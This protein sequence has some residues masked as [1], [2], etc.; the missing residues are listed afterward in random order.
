[1][2]TPEK[3]DYKE[4]IINLQE[5]SNAK[6]YGKENLIHQR[7]FDRA[8]KLI[9]ARLVRPEAIDKIRYNDTISILGS[10][11]SGKTSFLLSLLANYKDSK[12]VEVLNII[13]PTLIEEK[14]HVFLT[15]ISLI[16]ESVSKRLNLSDCSPDDSSYL[17]KKEW[18]DKLRKLAD[19]LPSMDGVGSS[20]EHSDWQDTEFIM[21][22][23]LKSVKAA[24]NLEANFN[25]LVCCALRALEK[26]VFI[27][28]LDDIDVDFRKGW[29]VLE[30]I[31]KY[32]TSP[33]IIVLLSGDLKLYAKAIRKQQWKNFGKALLKNEAEALNKMNEY[34][35]LVTEMEGQ[36]MQKVIKPENRIRLTTLFEKIE[37]YN[38]KIFILKNSSSLDK[39]TDYNEHLILNFYNSILKTFGIQSKNQA[40]AYTSF[41][42]NLPLRTQIQFLIESQKLVQLDNKGENQKQINPITENEENRANI[43]DAFLSD[44]YEK[45]VDV[46]LARNL[47]KMLS[48][49][50]LKLLIK[51]RI[52]SEAYQ[53]QPTTIDTS[54]NS[55]L[56]ALSFLYSQHVKRNPYLIFDYFI[57]IGYT[58]N[59][60]D[61]IGYKSSR[62]KESDVLYSIDD[63]CQSSGIY[64]DKVLRDITGN[65]TSYVRG[66][67]NYPNENRNKKYAGII[68]LTGLASRAKGK[69]RE[70][71]VDEVFKND[72]DGL[73]LASIP[74]TISS[75]N[76]KNSTLLTSSIYVLLASI[77]ELV[78]LGTI[79]DIL[80][81][82]NSIRDAEIANGI[83]E[84]SQI[85][86]YVMPNFNR[87]D[88]KPNE[89]GSNEEYEEEINVDEDQ[90]T[91]QVLVLARIMREWI[92]RYPQ[93]I[94]SISP[95]LL[96]KI[97][98]RFFY[99]LDSIEIQRTS[100]LGDCM[101]RRIIALANAI[102]IEEI[103]EHA[104]KEINKDK[105]FKSKLWTFK[106]LNIDNTITDDRVFK[107]NLKVAE[108]YKEDLLLS[109]WLLSCP[110]F[111][112]YLPKSS[113][114]Q[115]EVISKYIDF[116]SSGY[117][118]DDI[119]PEV[120]QKHSI[121]EK[122]KNIVIFGLK[123]EFEKSRN[124]LDLSDFNSSKI[125]LL[126]SKFDCSYSTAEI[127]ILN[128]I[129]YSTFKSTVNKNGKLYNTKRNN[130]VREK[131]SSLFS[132]EDITNI[133]I[134]NFIEFIET[135]SGKHAE[136]I[137]KWKQGQL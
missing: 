134:T 27:I 104:K 66:V 103:K 130:N 1:M 87:Q 111:L 39:K 127:L 9:N 65:I 25:D 48:V 92:D 105:L 110:L 113:D 121:Y 126:K 112:V 8:T 100:N 132:K 60:I 42:L 59:L 90:I 99:A 135:Y 23:G 129:P 71:R 31:R 21:D 85:R 12:E 38:Y 45:E 44:L 115:K 76:W 122:S 96:G 73:R 33:Q 101:Y 2:E 119:K 15:V 30:T 68:P 78:K 108:I 37:S 74:M 58:R 57:K 53:L 13:D 91:D 11:G 128:K 124:K 102:V 55:S 10:R 4:I 63:L 106:D 54:L 82:D 125:S 89:T 17:Q 118:K 136:T 16:E 131:C 109:R 77:G 24:S 117:K 79:Q 116:I 107:K 137:E 62:V 29:P 41:L 28:T 84:L 123:S 14:G 95:H 98:T 35:D 61:E 97:S 120:I 18:K 56:A 94:I 72:E 19:G 5:S 81:V 75:N 67:I 83:I 70:Y 36:Y 22:R 114:N 88:A 6:S 43:I 34:N 50:I 80:L 32:L 64:Q 86:N 93:E 69:N 40:E 51:E 46:D 7:E 133:M 26:K 52:L 20:L 47:P 49:V 3:N